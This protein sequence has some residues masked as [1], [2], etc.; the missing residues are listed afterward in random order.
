MKKTIFLLFFVLITYN[1][2]TSQTCNWSGDNRGGMESCFSLYNECSS[3]CDD[4]YMFRL[5]NITSRVSKDVCEAWWHF[6]AGSW[7]EVFFDIW[8]IINDCG[9]YL[10]QIWEAESSYS[11]CG[12]DAL[13]K[14]NRCVTSLEND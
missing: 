9:S 14:L 1:K 12:T 13:H 4:T 5:A 6:G 8:D 7:G 10:P 11:A 2:S 3:F